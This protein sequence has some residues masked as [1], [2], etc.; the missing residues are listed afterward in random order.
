MADIK[1]AR[2][3]AAIDPELDAV[4]S[5]SMHDPRRWESNAMLTPDYYSSAD[6]ESDRSFP[7]IS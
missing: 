6:S 5:L 4:R 3:S 7:G 2:S 1:D